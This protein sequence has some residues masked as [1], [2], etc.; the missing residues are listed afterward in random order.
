MPAELLGGADC[1][2]TVFPT[3]PAF[4][5]ASVERFIGIYRMGRES[6]T[7]SRQDDRFLAHR[8]RFG[9]RELRAEA[10]GAATFRDGCGVRYAFAPSS[11]VITDLDGTASRWNR[12]GY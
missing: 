8:V 9:V 1:A 6:V 5:P 10:V 7:V 4:G 11:L 12:R 3:D 2:S